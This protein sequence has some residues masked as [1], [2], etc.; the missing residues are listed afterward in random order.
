MSSSYFDWLSGFRSGSPIEWSILLGGAV[1]LVLLLIVVAALRR[2][3]KRPLPEPPSLE[4]DLQALDISAPA[5]KS[6]VLECHHVPGRL[7]VLVLAPVGRGA[8]LPRD[9]AGLNAL[10]DC[11][12]PG[13]AEVVQQ[14]APHIAHWPAQL[15]PRG[16]ANSFFSN[17][18]LPGQRG[19]AT[20]WCAVA[21]KFEGP[22]QMYMAGLA[23]VADAPNSLTQFVIERPSDWLGV[24]KVRNRD[25]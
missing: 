23:I 5:P 15:S 11:I 13:F 16:F 20:P 1:L 24:V 8:D 17:V 21:G 19:K 14:H 10:A 7:A 4:I 22:G 6:P 3:R 18:R 9:A 12:V 2:R 25:D